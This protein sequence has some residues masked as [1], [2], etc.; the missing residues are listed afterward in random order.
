MNLLLLIG[1]SVLPAIAIVAYFY[2]L[3]RHEREPVRMIL[4]CFIFGVI[5]T[6]PA[7]K[8]EEFGILDIYVTA[9]DN[10]LM[11]FTFAFL[12]VAFSEELMKFIF[13]RYY[14]FNK[15]DFNE[16]LDGIVY[17]IAISM[18]FASME[19]ILHIVIRT[20][21]FKEALEIGYSRT[22]TAVPAHAAFAMS[23]G[24]FTGLA[25]K[26]EYRKSILLMAGLSSAIF[27]HGLYDFF[28]FLEWTESLTAYTFATLII[29]LLA[30]KYL[31]FKHIHSSSIE[32][33]S[34]A[35]EKI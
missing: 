9:S 13:L 32:N 19:N 27:L 35:G 16:P 1:L 5:S 21:D 6:Y 2:L 15:A 28:I 8:M 17:S 7:L 3:D 34:R 12:I 18:G 22:L 4:L 33:R 23:M 25:K 24:Y 26:Q 10:F 30:G 14:I 29:A 11:T 20:E 31:T